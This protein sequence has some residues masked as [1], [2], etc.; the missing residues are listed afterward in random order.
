MCFLIRSFNLPSLVGKYLVK[1]STTIDLRRVTSVLHD[2]SS[3]FGNLDRF[4]VSKTIE[5]AGMRR[6]MPTRMMA[7]DM[8]ES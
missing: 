7:C 8:N 1:L 5:A 3:A 4:R 2:T 6:C